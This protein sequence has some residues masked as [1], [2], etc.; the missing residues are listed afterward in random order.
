M[1][2]K[3]ITE[4]TIKTAWELVN[5]L[6]SGVLQIP[7]VQR[8]VVWEPEDVKKLI[9]S[10]YRDYPCGSL[11]LWEP[12]LRDV[13]LVRDLIRPEILDS[14]LKEDTDYSPQ[15]F[16]IDGQQRITA[17]ASVIFGS[18][19]LKTRE[20]E[21][22]Y[23]WPTFYINLENL[24]E[25]EAS[26]EAE[27]Y[28]FPWVPIHCLFDG[29]LANNSKY[30][31]LS[32]ECLREVRSFCDQLQ[33][34]KFPV[35]IIKGFD[36]PT[37][38]EIF[39]RVNSQ[40]TLLTGAEIYIAQIVPHW[41]GITR[42][43]RN[44]LR[45][46]KSKQKYLLDL[47]FLM[48]CLTVIATEQPKIKTFADRVKTG[49]IK[50]SA[51]NNLWHICRKNIN[52]LIKILQEEVYLDKSKFF[53]SKNV[54]VPLVYYLHK[55]EYRKPNYKD[56]LKF[57]LLSQIG[58]H[59]ARGTESVLRK[60]IRCI[61]ESELSRD[62]LKE[63]CKRVYEEAR[64][65][66][67]LKGMNLPANE[68]KGLPS[69]NSILL[70]MYVVMNKANAKDFGLATPKN[71]S[72]LLPEELTLHHIFPFKFMQEDRYAQLYKRQ[73]NLSTSEF[74]AQVND[75][76]NLTFLSKEQN[77]SIGDKSPCEYLLNLTTKDNLRAHFI[78]LTKE[79]WKPINFDRFLTERRKLLSEAINKFLKRLS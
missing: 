39:E 67:R 13:N 36:Y 9:D 30:N 3:K 28:E 66:R 10:I 16:L 78:P 62:A 34:Y 23:N 17:L 51:L 71:L 49:K 79:Y 14:F 6:K 45:E 43:F 60:D 21:S 33:G 76:A 1:K 32:S 29:S 37:V 46:L 19:F 22:E 27:Y 50:K 31:K 58:E 69:R 24:H 35:Q 59:Y 8:D 53:T 5:D 65:E 41:K 40:G 25:I 52:K 54:L 70:L 63:V 2:Q 15:Y 68:I 64:D 57:F 61:R 44:Y 72:M 77:S 47:T 12:R 48:R 42:Q 75:I 73:K 74:N 4:P 56:I 7:E 55:S 11:I 18:D 26:Y 20:P 38:G